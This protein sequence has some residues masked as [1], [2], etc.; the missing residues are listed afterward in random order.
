MTAKLYG[1]P[2]SQNAAIAEAMLRH[3]G[4]SYTRR[5]LIPGV[6][7]LLLVR[8]L[9]F[10]GTT[11]PALKIDGRRVLGTRLIARALDQQQPDPALFPADPDLRRRVEDGERFGAEVM[12]Q[13]PRH[14][15]WVALKRDPA[16]A[17]SFLADA[18]LGFPT[19]LAAPA[20]R[21]VIGLMCR[22]NNASDTTA[23][24]HLPGI[25]AAL[26]HVDQLI[27]DST[28]GSELPN[29]A[30]FQLGAQ[31]RILMCFDDLRPLVERHRCARLATTL[32]PAQPGRIPPLLSDDERA[33]L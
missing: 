8:L 26:A 18:R 21:P 30:D 19:Q 28:I 9:G 1:I 7:R 25:P 27:A 2:G 10:P 20:I 16:A 12:Q 14:I 31:V 3:K 17:K 29:A 5:D 32:Y 15:L 22:L 11:V 23:H 33:L 6:H 4:I 24:A 13:F